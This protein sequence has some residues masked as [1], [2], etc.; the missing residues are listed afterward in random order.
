LEIR[1]WCYIP[2]NKSIASTLAVVTEVK[3]NFSGKILSVLSHNFG[4]TDVCSRDEG[5]L[6]QATDLRLLPQVSEQRLFQF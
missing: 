6:R 1:I 2:E 4:A 3:D 5:P